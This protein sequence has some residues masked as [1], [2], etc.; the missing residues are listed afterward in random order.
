[1]RRSTEQRGFTI[2][3][4]MI[5]LLIL[6][7]VTAQVM[8]VFGTQRRTAL[9][10]DRLLD[11]QAGARTVID[12]IAHDL[13][14]AGMLVPRVAGVSSVDGGTG[15]A[16]RLCVSDASYFVTPLDGSPSPSL[17]N[18]GSHFTNATVTAVTA[19]G[20]F[21]Q[22]LDID[23]AGSTI[24]FVPGDGIIVSDG[25]KTHC[26]QIVA[27][28]GN[29][30]NLEPT[31]MIPGGTF[32][33]TAGLV[34]VPAII[35]ELDE[36]NLTLMRNGVTLATSTED[37]QVEYWVDNQMPDGL[38]GGTEFPI[39]DLNAS[40]GAWQIQTDRISRVRVSV[41]ARTDVGDSDGAVVSQRYR[42]PAS[43]NR[44]QGAFDEF[45]RRRFSVSLTPRNL[46]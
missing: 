21:L 26:A 42:R 13:R 34:A 38:V 32:A 45:R 29:Q 37:L 33:S 17:D 8:V 27:I 10:S 22:S 46:F 16:D 23:D 20:V 36:P 25:N 35:Y 11:V 43:A 3:E 2:I 12:L 24:D 30:I 9:V 40:P 4:L 41:V 6:G 28:F 18:R 39:H 14:M 7:I 1:M 5:A 44:T 19:M 31:H 15:G